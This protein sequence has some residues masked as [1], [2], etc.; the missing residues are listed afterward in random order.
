M[1]TPATLP[2]VPSG[3]ARADRPLRTTK[4]STPCASRRTAEGRSFVASDVT[5]FCEGVAATSAD[6]GHLVFE[7]ELYSSK[8]GSE[9]L[10]AAVADALVTAADRAL[11]CLGSATSRSPLGLP[12]G[13]PPPGAAAN[14]RRTMLLGSTLEHVR[15]PSLDDP[16]PP[17]LSRHYFLQKTQWTQTPL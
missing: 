10:S 4:G 5:P 3:G 12:A 11:S 2:R 1:S 14:G 6:A 9:P 8:A 13:S 16:K 17:P 7:A 15:G